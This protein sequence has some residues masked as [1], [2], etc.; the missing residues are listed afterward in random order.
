[1]TAVTERINAFELINQFKAC[2]I[3]TFNR[4]PALECTKKL[5]HEG[6]LRILDILNGEALKPNKEFN[7]DYDST[8]I[9]DT[10]VDFLLKNNTEPQTEL[11]NEVAKASRIY[12]ECLALQTYIPD[13]N[14]EFPR[15]SK[16]IKD[17]ILSGFEKA[18]NLTA[19]KHVA[20]RYE[21]KCAHRAALKIITNENMISKYTNLV[22]P[23]ISAIVTKDVSESL[24]ALYALMGAASKD[25]STGKEYDSVFTLSWTSHALLQRKVKLELFYE[26]SGKF[27]PYKPN[28]AFCILETITQLYEK[29][30]NVDECMLLLKGRQDKPGIFTFVNMEIPKDKLT[31]NKR[32]L[33]RSFDKVSSTAVSK[34]KSLQGEKQTAGLMGK[35]DQYWK[36]RHR[37]IDHLKRLSI[38][39]EDKEKEEIFNIMAKRIEKEYVKPVINLL[40]NFHD[41]Y[42]TDDIWINMASDI[43]EN[44]DKNIEKLEG[45]MKKKQDIVSGFKNRNAF[46]SNVEGVKE[47][48]EL[49]E[50]E[51]M[52]L[53]EFHLQ[54]E[55]IES[56]E[57][58]KSMF[59]DEE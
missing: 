51:L 50:E 24:K 10:L 49:N 56:S 39:M 12:T 59:E 19:L 32:K 36:V 18:R 17:K 30:D 57:Q 6:S 58:K 14:G 15:F 46:E 54:M 5:Y 48:K 55:K 31:R 42:K 16:E 41:T 52:D 22:S 8:L 23:L 1:M 11:R 53:L 29:S 33:A 34:I 38:K 43:Y 25:L 9:V 3:D 45:K 47:E 40:R 35:L 20:M 7:E 44:S 2:A 37:A 13:H 4:T 28:I 26:R 27:I 21:L